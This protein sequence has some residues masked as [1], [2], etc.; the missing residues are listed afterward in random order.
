MI[1]ALRLFSASKY[2]YSWYELFNMFQ[3]WNIFI[4]DLIFWTLQ[5]RHIFIHDLSIFN[6]FRIGNIFIHDLSFPDI[7]I[8]SIIIWAFST[9][10][11]FQIFSSWSEIFWHNLDSKYIIIHYLR[12]FNT[13]SFSNYFYLWSKLLRL[14]SVLKYFHSWV[15]L[16]RNVWAFSTLSFMLWDSLILIKLINYVAFR[17]SFRHICVVHTLFSF[18]IFL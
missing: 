6:T 3:I 11:S 18:E 7:E 15:G 2:F 12:F 13:F 14:F 5:I 16:F 10:F 9:L 17:P 4:G 1:W 8:F